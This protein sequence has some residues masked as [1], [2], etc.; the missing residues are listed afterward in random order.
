MLARLAYAAGAFTAAAELSLRPRNAAVVARSSTQTP[1]QTAGQGRRAQGW[2]APSSGPNDAVISGLATMRQ[3]ARAAVRNDGLAKGALGRLVTNIIGTGIKPQSMAP[4]EA[5]RT[6]VQNL[7]A[8]WADESDA[9]GLLDFYG[10]QALAVRSCLES[11]EMFVR[12][13]PRLLSDGLTVPLQLQLLES[14]QCAETFT[15]TADNGNVVRAGIEFDQL[16]RRVAYWMWKAHPG[17]SV[18]QFMT[19]QQRVPVPADLVVHMYDPCRPGQLRGTTFLAQ[20]LV[21]LKDRN[22]LMDAALLRQKLANLITGFLKRPAGAGGDLVLDPLTGQPIQTDATGLPMVAFEPGTFQELGPGEDVA[23]SNPPGVDQ[24]F[25][26]FGRQLLMD[27][28]VGVEIPYEVLTGDLSRINDRTARMMLNEFRRGIQRWQAHV[29]AQQLNRRVWEAWWDRALLAGALTVPPTD[30]AARP[31]YY[32]AV[33][34]TPQRFAYIN[35]V[36]DVQARREEI[37]AGLTS[38]RRMVS[39]LGD[40]IE[41]VDKEIAADNARADA[42]GLIFD[43]DPRQIGS[44]GALQTAPANAPPAEGGP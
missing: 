7:W 6:E 39:E 33:Q 23:F 17:D 11:G 8:R 4:T 18:Q 20:T 2:Y 27:V 34:W 10:Q 22:E 38:R 26:T 24:S 44:N 25:E 1:Y 36:Q 9:D 21:T 16:G 19:V 37:R 30:Y 3:R 13:R 5:L 29:I 41:V 35:P 40:D 15:T 28:A 42:L 31:W 32:R 14:E 43:S 12:L